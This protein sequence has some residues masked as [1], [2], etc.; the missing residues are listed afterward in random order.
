MTGSYFIVAFLDPA[1]ELSFGQNRA[2]FPRGWY[3]Y[4]G[5]AMKALEKRVVRHLCPTKKR[6]WHIDYLLEKASV[7]AVIIFPSP[8]REECQKSNLLRMIGGRVV[9]KG[10]G[11]TD[12]NC[13]TH[14]Y[15]FPG[16]PLQDPRV[17]EAL[18]LS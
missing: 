9:A 13:E 11:S 6:H 1:C 5:S 7:E 16:N 8:K 17:L 14:L 10:F 2:Y 15:F 3:V 18:R 4:V 12:C